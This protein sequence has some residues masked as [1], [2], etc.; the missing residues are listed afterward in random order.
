MN[1]L[2]F[3]LLGAG[4]FLAGIYKALETAMYRKRAVVCRAR[5]SGHKAFRSA[6]TGSSKRTYRAAVDI[7][8]PD[9]TM[10]TGVIGGLS[11]SSRVDPVG[12]ELDV[13][14]DPKKVSD[15]RKA[16]PI[17]LFAQPLAFLALGFVLGL[18]GY[19]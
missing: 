6:E 14:V 13:L 1:D 18:S 9:G 3:M 19:F 4:F 5:V 7:L 16:K 17:S 2:I 15:V 10:G 12:T 11:F 8:Y